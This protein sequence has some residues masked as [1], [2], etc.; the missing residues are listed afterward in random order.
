ML[1][2]AKAAADGE[3][4]SAG[5]VGIQGVLY[6]TTEYGGAPGNDGTVFEV[7]SVGT[8]KVLYSFH[9]YSDGDDGANP[10]AGLVSINGTLY[11]STE[12]GGEKCRSANGSGTVFSVSASGTEKVLHSF[13]VTGIYPYDGE[14]PLAGLTSFNRRLWGATEF[15]GQ[16]P[17]QNDPGDAGMVFSL[18]TTGAE[19]ILYLFDVFSQTGCY[20]EAR[21]TVSKARCM[22]LPRAAV[23]TTGELSWTFTIHERPRLG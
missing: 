19:N 20:P 13:C 8:E 5:L 23:C 10:V 22:V 2:S 17:Y 1:Y 16:L 6:G 12:N 7:D 14:N 9:G 18:S 11:G 4:P 15:G 3:N 21:L